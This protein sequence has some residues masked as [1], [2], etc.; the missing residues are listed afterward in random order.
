MGVPGAGM[1]RRPVHWPG[2]G[3]AQLENA[4]GLLACLNYLISIYDL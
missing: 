2:L 4:Q 3:T 1:Y